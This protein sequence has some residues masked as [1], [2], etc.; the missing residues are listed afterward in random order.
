MAAVGDSITAGDSPDLAGGVAGTESWVSHASDDDIEFV[1]GWA[2]WG[3]STEIM[4]AAVRDPIDADVLVLLGGTNDLGWVP[5]AETAENLSLIAE[6]ADVEAVVISSI[7]PLDL[8][9]G[10]G[11]Q[12]LNTFLMHYAESQGWNWVDAAEGLREGSDFAPGMS[13]DGVHLSEQGAGVLGRAIADAVRE[14]TG[15]R[16]D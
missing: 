5:H 11:T 7:P 13:Y 16:K 9:Q 6:R 14:A 1:G 4:A 8:F 2:E 12:D 3:A 15:L 10:A